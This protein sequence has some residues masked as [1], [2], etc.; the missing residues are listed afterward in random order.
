MLLLMSS[1][2]PFLL[3]AE[4]RDETQEPGALPRRL[5]IPQRD[6]PAALVPFVTR[7]PSR[8]VDKAHPLN[9]RAV[10]VVTDP[11]LLKRRKLDEIAAAVSEIQRCVSVLRTLQAGKK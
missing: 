11:H 9:H 2:K 3:F 8:P 1:P 5:E 6:T 10:G 4:R 7:E